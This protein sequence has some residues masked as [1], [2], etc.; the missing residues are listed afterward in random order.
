MITI[1]CGPGRTG[2]AEQGFWWNNIII[3]YYVKAQPLPSSPPYLLAGVRLGSIVH[4]VGLV[5]VCL[6]CARRTRRV[7]GYYVSGFHEFRVVRARNLCRRL[8]SLVRFLNTKYPATVTTVTG[9]DT[10]R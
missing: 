1:I 3:Y 7:Q 9:S 4:P 5:Y 10:L 8:W 2:R 6:L